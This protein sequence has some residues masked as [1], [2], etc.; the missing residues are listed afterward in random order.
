M[1]EQEW[2]DKVEQLSSA[3]KDRCDLVIPTTAKYQLSRMIFEAV[4]RFNE[5]DL[6]ILREIL[7]DNRDWMVFEAHQRLKIEGILRGFWIEECAAD[8][9][10]E[11]LFCV[12]KGSTDI[13]KLK[14]VTRGNFP[15]VHKV[16]SDLRRKEVPYVNK[17]REGF[18]QLYEE[19]NGAAHMS[20]RLILSSYVERE[21]WSEL[22]SCIFQ[23]GV[24]ALRISRISW[25]ESHVNIIENEFKEA[26]RQLDS[27]IQESPD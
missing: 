19:A 3:W 20:V 26:L 14:L 4:W 18:I 11:N 9:Q 23:M 25:D 8:D 6:K 17:K 1:K 22:R 21:V 10:L 24:C 5:W 7:E 13:H 12:D 15:K 2:L 16:I 27:Q